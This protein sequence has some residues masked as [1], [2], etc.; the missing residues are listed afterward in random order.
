[1]FSTRD[2]CFRLAFCFVFSGILP[3]PRETARADDMGI[4]GEELLKMLVQTRIDGEGSLQARAA[5]ERLVERDARVLPQILLAM[6]DADAVGVNWL[7]TAADAIVRRERRSSDPQIPCDDLR[8]IVLNPL[9]DSR[10]RRLALSMLESEE[11]GTLKRLLPSLLE[12]RA[13][14]LDAVEMLIA[15]ADAAL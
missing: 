7:R 13:F 5:W 1:M 8:A 14:R 11:P 12:D 6:K 3:V 10:A 9:C 15:D 4:A 2:F